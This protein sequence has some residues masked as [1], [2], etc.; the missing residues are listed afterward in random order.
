MGCSVSSKSQNRR[1][2][3]FESYFIRV[4]RFQKRFTLKQRREKRRRGRTDVIKPNSYPLRPAPVPEENFCFYDALQT[5]L[6]E[7]AAL[8]KTSDTL[9]FTIVCY[10]FQ[11][12]DFQRGYAASERVKKKTKA[13]QNFK[14]IHFG[15][16]MG[17]LKRIVV[18]FSEGKFLIS[19]PISGSGS[20]ESGAPAL[21]GVQRFPKFWP[22]PPEQLLIEWVWLYVYA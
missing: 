10:Y 3:S 21:F 8:L 11:N 13:L 1:L 19:D 6:D 17:T 4:N 14:C 12:A 16:E 9:I 20:W 5:L 18:L 15:K 7:T 2:Q 22:K